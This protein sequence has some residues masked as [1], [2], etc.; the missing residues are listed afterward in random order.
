[1]KRADAW[2][3]AMH[4]KGKQF[5][6]QYLSFMSPGVKCSQVGMVYQYHAERAGLPSQA[7]RLSPHLP[8][9]WEVEFQQ[10]APE[11]PFQ[12]A[13]CE[14]K[15]KRI[16]CFRGNLSISLAN[17]IKSFLPDSSP[18]HLRTLQNYR[19]TTDFLPA[20]LES[21]IDQTDC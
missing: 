4:S 15:G 9:N 19:N 17:L 8:S 13:L 16:T 18:W 6:L 12:H 14:K 3:N 10:V 2:C 1:M 11:R 5:T 20:A 21:V 7:A